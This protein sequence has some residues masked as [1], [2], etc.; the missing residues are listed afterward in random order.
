M[1]HFRE[2]VGELLAADLE[3]DQYELTGDTILVVEVFEIVELAE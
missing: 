3:A 2:V 1:Q